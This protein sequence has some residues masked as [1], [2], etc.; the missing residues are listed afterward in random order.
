[1]GDVKESIYKNLSGE[2]VAKFNVLHTIYFIL[3]CDV[4]NHT[5][6]KKGKAVYLTLCNRFFDVT[7]SFIAELEFSSCLVMLHLYI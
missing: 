3:H 5:L 2:G 6:K 7:V 4:R 1:M